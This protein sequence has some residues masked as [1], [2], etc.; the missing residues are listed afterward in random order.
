M[1]YGRLKSGTWPDYG[2]IRDNILTALIKGYDSACC[3]LIWFTAVKYRRLG[4]E[5]EQPSTFNIVR[6]SDL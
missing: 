3:K 5:L 6:L 1:A 4:S 2:L